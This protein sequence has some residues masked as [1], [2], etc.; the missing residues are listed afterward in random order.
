MRI[1]LWFLNHKLEFLKYAISKAISRWEEEGGIRAG[2]GGSLNSEKPMINIL[3]FFNFWFRYKLNPRIC[4]VLAKSFRKYGNIFYIGIKNQELFEIL[5]DISNFN[6][7]NEFALQ[8][9]LWTK[10]DINFTDFCIADWFK[11]KDNPGTLLPWGEAKN[12]V[13]RMNYNKDKNIIN[14]S[15]EKLMIDSPLG[16]TP[17]KLKQAETFLGNLPKISQKDYEI[18]SIND[19]MIPIKFGNDIHQKAA[20]IGIVTML[21]KIVLLQG[22]PGTGKTEIGI[23]ALIYILRNGIASRC[24][25]LSPTHAARKMAKKRFVKTIASAAFPDIPFKT[26]HS[27]ITSR[28]THRFVFVDELSM[29]DSILLYRMMQKNTTASYIFMGDY[30][31]LMPID[32]GTPF[33]DFIN[34]FESDQLDMEGCKIYILQNNYRSSG[35]SIPGLCSRM[36]EL[37][38]TIEE[39]TE[40]TSKDEVKYY[41]TSDDTAISSCIK[42]FKENGYFPDSYASFHNFDSESLM[43]NFRIIVATNEEVRKY[44]Q[45]VKKIFWPM[46]KPLDGFAKD[47]ILVCNINIPNIIY[48]GD[49]VSVLK[50][51][52]KSIIVILNEPVVSLISTTYDDIHIYSP[53]SKPSFVSEK[54]WI[55]ILDRN[56]LEIS[57]YIYQ[58]IFTLAYVS[59]VHKAQGSEQ[60]HVIIISSKNCILHTIQWIYTAISRA[61]LCIYIFMPEIVIN[62]MILREAIV[63]K[64]LLRQLL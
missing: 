55:H 54:Y 21:H 22:G 32:R 49:F 35:A 15:I 34:R 41:D 12:W 23:E 47:D 62:R 7:L 18:F 64:T 10:G 11:K 13:Y 46:R 1:H 48:N 8:N 19:N 40:Y 63:P 33:Y 42:Q 16:Y 50:I 39:L 28:E 2:F 43:S 52:K 58:K 30:N 53:Y 17:R 61:K 3:K 36:L 14:E 38:S 59:T 20:F 57:F 51:T 44:N 60:D 4:E 5:F 6:C 56:K 24:I 45:L 25:W 9:E 27:Y 29:V 31:Q 26:I 37:G